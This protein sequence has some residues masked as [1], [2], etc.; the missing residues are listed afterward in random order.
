VIADDDR[1]GRV[2]VV[3]GVDGA[4]RSYRLALLAAREDL[5]VVRVGP[6]SAP[7]G[8]QL[9]TDL[10]SHRPGTVL[11]LVDDAHRLPVAT[12]RV[13]L[14]A[15]RA[16]HRMI[17]AR[18][19]SIGSPDLAALDETL[20]AGGRVEALA[21]LD[22]AGTAALVRLVTGRDCDPASARALR[23]ASA[24]RPA[25]AAAL[26]T[27]P[28]TGTGTG[29]DDGSPALR[30]RL[31]Q[32]LAMLE[33]AA[34]TVATVLALDLALPDDALAQACE[35]SLPGLETARLALRDA[36]LLH[37]DGEHLVPAVGAALLADTPPG[38]RRRLHDDVARALVAT[39]APALDAARQLRAA[40]ARGPAAAAVYAAAAHELRF[41]DPAAALGWY[42]DASDAGAP[43]AS[44]AAGRAE[45]GALLGLPVDPDTDGLSA[46]DAL[47]VTLAVGAAAAHEGRADRAGDA[48]LGAGAPGPAL[49]V[50]ALIGAGRLSDARDAAATPAPASVRL[51]AGA[52][53]AGTDPGHALALAI[54]AGEAL[55]R[56]PVPLVLPDTPHALGAVFAV[57]GGDAATAAHL[58]ERAVRQDIGGPVAAPR[59]RLLAAW[60]RMRAGRLEAARAELAGIEGLDGELNGRDR[61]YRAALRAGLA[62]RGGDIGGLRLVWPEVERVLAR[63]GL[64]LFQLEA[65]EELA[66]AAARLR[67][68]PRMA[69][70]LAGLEA[71]VAGLGSPPDW[72]VALGWLHLQVAVASDDSAAAG[73]AAGRI[74]AADPPGERARAQQAAAGP[75]AAALAGRV[76]PAAVLE[77]TG[78]LAEAEMPWEASR[79]A[80]DAAIRIA[81]PAAA[82][83]LLERA[84]D[85]A[86]P[87]PA[88]T[89]GR[90][91]DPAQ[92]AG[93]SEREVEVATL[94]LAGRTHREIGTQLYIAPK[95][96]EHHVARIR[97][98][99]GA[100]TRAEFVAALRALLEPVP[101]SAP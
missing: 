86:G 92:Q 8:A 15:A 71:V 7:D 60:A 58:L 12:L 91:A 82:R 54:E 35:L 63:R 75:W 68:L 20:A 53:L 62:R 42:D 87:D 9:A 67:R 56:T 90:A 19:P 88:P 17:L 45:A 13:L 70:S 6:G 3:V 57:A 52:A 94:V 76:D 24:G 100:T 28:G 51:I 29:P 81:D 95:T 2:A 64:D 55:E 18:R 65:A 73:T 34:T 78:L 16:G 50:P 40:R 83:R 36:G 49:A 101:G 84:R 1:S 38:R 61:V 5:P 47:R 59:H 31:Q 26:A 93:L 4:G 33:P 21:E 43:P 48:L 80:G 46:D 89:G 41:G 37:P 32:R 30:A 77:A 39:G 96:V 25:I 66:V 23:R 72:E 99:V 85:L 44:V 14:S 79:L 69:P 22:D 27:G 98:K 74:A 11:V 97:T 10:E